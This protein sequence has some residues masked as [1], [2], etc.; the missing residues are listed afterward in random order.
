MSDAA[1][2]VWTPP[3]AGAARE[4]YAAAVCSARG[5]MT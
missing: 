5:E 4:P 3:I 1:I 2:A